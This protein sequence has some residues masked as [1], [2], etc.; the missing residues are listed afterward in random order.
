MHKRTLIYS[1]RRCYGGDAARSDGLTS[2]VMKAA[3]IK[4]DESFILLTLM[5][6]FPDYVAVLSCLMGAA[7]VVGFW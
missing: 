5:P 1:L 2:L 6:I 4:G 3:L 7:T